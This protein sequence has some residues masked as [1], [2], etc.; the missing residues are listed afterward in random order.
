MFKQ[1]LFQLQ[2]VTHRL[3][4]RAGLFALLA[5]VSSLT[6]VLLGAYVPEEFAELAGG[7]AVDNILNV[8]A[9]SMLIVATFAL[10]TMVAAYTAA[11]QHTTPR[12]TNLIIND[13]KSQSAISI[14]LGA[15]IYSVVSLIALS[16]E[17]YGPKGRVIL[18]IMTVIVLTA[19]VWVIIRWVE[20]LR[21]MGSVHETI[22]RVEC[23]TAKALAYRAERPTFGCMSI[24]KIPSSAKAIRSCDVGYI[25]NIDIDFLGKLAEEESIEMYIEKDVGGYVH[26]QSNLVFIVSEK[27]I[28]EKLEKKIREA[29][30][31]GDQRTFLNDPRFGL[32]VLSGIGI[33]ALSPSLN[34]PGTAIDVIGSLMRVLIIWENQRATCKA[35]DPKYRR[36]FFPEMVLSDLYNDAFYGLIKESA[37]HLEV[38]KAMQSGMG[39]LAQSASVESKE[40]ALKHLEILNQRSREE[41]TSEVDTRLIH[42]SSMIGEN[43]RKAV[44]K[45]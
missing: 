5:V 34:D 7:Y 40:V 45:H 8:M 32:S 6:A 36:V 2:K 21:N 24:D 13:S 42:A 39:I 26:L 41:L 37:K 14:F 27:K 33:K 22:R 18:L 38:V 31:V 15:F 9:S 25:Q 11:T 20:E 17:Y 19:V 28:S 12:A 30:A 23:A 16:T 3:S 43:Q 10:S 1:W 29:F 35:A 4:V 44:D